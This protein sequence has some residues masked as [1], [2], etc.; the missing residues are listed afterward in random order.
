MSEVNASP[1]PSTENPLV[2]ERPLAYTALLGLQGRLAIGGNAL[3][4]STTQELNTGVNEQNKPATVA[5]MDKAS[6]RER[7]TYW[8]SQQE[9]DKTAQ[10]TAWK[11]SVVEKITALPQ[12]PTGRDHAEFFTKMGINPAQF[13][14]G[15]AQT[16]YNTYFSKDLAGKGVNIFIENVR[17]AFSTGGSLDREALKARLPA[18]QWMAGMFGG[19]SAEIIAQL[20]DAEIDNADQAA[21]V[22]ARKD[23]VNALEEHE[24]ELLTFLTK[25]ETIQAEAAQPIVQPTQNETT[26][27]DNSGVQAQAEA[28]NPVSTNPVAEVPT[29]VVTPTNTTTQIETGVTQ[30][31]TPDATPTIVEVTSPPVVDAT[32]SQPLVVEPPQEIITQPIVGTQSPVA[33]TTADNA[34]SQNETTAQAVQTPSQ[35]DA[36]TPEETESTVSNPESTQE[37]KHTQAELHAFQLIKTAFTDIKYKDQ[38]G[39]QM[40]IDPQFD[41]DQVIKLLGISPDDLETADVVAEI[42]E[43]WNSVVG[44]GNVVMEGGTIKPENTN[45]E[46]LDILGKNFLFSREESA[47]LLPII[48]YKFLSEEK[49]EEYKKLLQDQKSK[50]KPAEPATEELVISPTDQVTQE[51]RTQQAETGVKIPT[52]SEQTNPDATP[53]DEAI[54]EAE[55]VVEAQ[56][57]QPTAN[58]P[59][60]ETLPPAPEAT[61]PNTIDANAATSE[62]PD[63]EVAPEQPV[64]PTNTSMPPASDTTDVSLN[65]PVED[66][67]TVTESPAATATPSQ[68]V[69]Q[70]TEQPSQDISQTQQVETGVN[71]PVTDVSTTPNTTS[72]AEAEHTIPGETAGNLITSTELAA[73]RNKM[74]TD[75]GLTNVP[76]FLRNSPKYTPELQEKV[77]ALEKLIEQ[78][79]AYE[80]PQFPPAGITHNNPSPIIPPEIA[81]QI[82]EM[83]AAES[84]QKQKAAAAA[85]PPF[86]PITTPPP[87]H[88]S[89]QTT[90][91]VAEA[92]IKPKRKSLRDSINEL[93]G[94]REK[95][96]PPTTPENT[97]TPQAEETVPV[98]ENKQTNHS[99]TTESENTP[100]PSQPVEQPTEQPAQGVDQAQQI[101]TEAPQAQEPTPTVAESS[102]PIPD[103]PAPT[104]ASTSEP[105]VAE[106]AP[107]PPAATTPLPPPVAPV[108]ATP[109][110]AESTIN[111]EPVR[112]PDRVPQPERPDP[113]IELTPLQMESLKRLGYRPTKYI[114]EV[115]STHSI[116]RRV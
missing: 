25:G 86:Q 45:Q 50:E 55:V 69:E 98:E 88:T 29:E 12:S 59:P 57:G 24:K 100:P 104:N 58:V 93:F 18:L 73:L 56:S 70:P 111:P 77:N 5:L 7:T 27:P 40:P 107:E 51:D 109:A 10:L 49:S 91:P 114:S 17:Q 16:L 85:T 34:V 71:I 11:T 38:E 47:A 33:T 1:P 43:A 3:F 32:D 90:Q 68:P 74:Y 113:R 63:A 4:P 6:T 79:Q 115:S 89:T 96:V 64:N 28:Q 95:A 2:P 110:A 103:V 20:L 76:A 105:P 41:K 78:A 15:D 14:D 30:G 21:F 87:G 22:T 53:T 48:R 35:P 106:V 36:A 82:F 81:E 8:N 42:E 62:P 108:R 80:R 37:Y 75:A 101:N 44:A 66:T 67:S 31:A 60:E 94:R 99:T 9:Q 83:R 26:P 116:K 72:P 39:V 112:N 84:V 46:I 97:E 65:P 102:A 19:N 54:S 13:T 52:G 23:K 61:N 92:T